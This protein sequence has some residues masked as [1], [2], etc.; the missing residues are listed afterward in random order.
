MKIRSGFVSNSS[1]SSFLALTTRHPMIMQQLEDKLKPPKFETDKNSLDWYA[2]EE[3]EDSP[4]GCADYSRFYIKGTDLT[5]FESDWNI[6]MV[7]IQF[8]E[9]DLRTKTLAKIEKDL[10][11]E[12]EDYGIEIH[13]KVR[14]TLEYGDWGSD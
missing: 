10:R 14:F 7:G 9:S 4:I 6:E 5:L 12:L 11:K 2:L 8:D 13:E 3:Q 1:S